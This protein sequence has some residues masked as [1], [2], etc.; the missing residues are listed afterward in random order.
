MQCF[1][2]CNLEAI[3]L[4]ESWGLTRRHNQAR[5]VLNA[6]GVTSAL[7]SPIGSCLLNAQSW[8][9][10]C[11]LKRLCENTGNVL[12]YVETHGQ[13]A[14]AARF[15]YLGTEIFGGQ[16]TTACCSDSGTHCVSTIYLPLVCLGPTT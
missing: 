9:H 4:L 12:V 16:L 6:F 10:R 1:A 7:S 13:M 15:R 3:V 2:K 5:C 11:K 8:R 14:D